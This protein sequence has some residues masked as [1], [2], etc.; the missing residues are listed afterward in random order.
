MPH[1]PPPIYNVEH[2]EHVVNL[3]DPVPSLEQEFET[4]PNLTQEVTNFHNLLSLTHLLARR[5]IGKIHLVAYSQSHVVTFVG[6][7]A[8]MTKKVLDKVATKTIREKRRK[9]REEK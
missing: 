5:T 8:I 4:Q 6:Y 3:D 1:S 9:K 7:L 2:E